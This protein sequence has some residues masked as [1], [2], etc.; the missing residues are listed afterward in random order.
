MGGRLRQARLRKG[1]SQSGAAALC[2][3]SQQNISRY[4]EG[5]VE[6]TASALLALARLYEVSTDWLLTGQEA[7]ASNGPSPLTQELPSTPWLHDLQPRLASLDTNGQALVRGT[8][9]GLL[10][11][12]SPQQPNADAQPPPDEAKT[13]T[14]GQKAKRATG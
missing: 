12:L 7:T 9:V 2:G 14:G 13:G 10:N 1:L 11:S 3:V 4:E 6:P 5:A 8:L